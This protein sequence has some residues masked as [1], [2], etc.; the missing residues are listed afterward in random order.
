MP[1]SGNFG[2]A[3]AAVTLP[4]I[5][6][7]AGG[8]DGWRWAIG[9]TGIISILYGLIYYAMVSNTPKGS[10]YFAPKKTGSM[11]VTSRGDFVLYALM[12]AP[13]AMSLGLLAWK[14]GPSGLKMLSATMTNVVYAA[15]VTLYLYQLADMWRINAGVLKGEAVADI[16]RYKFRQ[17]A[18]LNVSYFVTFGSELAVVSTLPLFFK[19]TFGLSLEAAGFLVRKFLAHHV[20]CAPRRRLAQR[21]VWAADD[22]AHS[23]SPAR[24]SAISP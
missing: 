9:A 16:H 12:Q 11:E 13:L 22:P 1:G 6:Y 3:A 5:A 4:S 14:L 17:V 18:V 24:R 19:D 10:T 2:S 21:Q 15:L 7:W 23:A 20:L 8:A